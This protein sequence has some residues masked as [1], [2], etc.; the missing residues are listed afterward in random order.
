MAFVDGWAEWRSKLK[1]IRESDKLHGIEKPFDWF[2]FA[3]KIFTPL[4]LPQL[5]WGRSERWRPWCTDTFVVG[6]TIVLFYLLLWV[7]SWPQ[8]S[9]LI[10]F[11]LLANIIIILLNILFLTKIVG[12]V[13]SYER[14]LILFM[15]NVAQVVLIFAIFYRWERPDLEAKDALVMALLVFGTIGYEQGAKPIAAF[16]FVIDFMLLAVFLAHFVRRLWEDRGTKARP[17]EAEVPTES[18]SGE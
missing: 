16:Q 13:A 4:Q 2:I 9:F 10:A 14:T 3:L 12:R 1:E 5:F 6:A 8:L 7:D 15:L 17:D 18:S 11:Y